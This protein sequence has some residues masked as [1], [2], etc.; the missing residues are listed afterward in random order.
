MSSKSCFNRI[1]RRSRNMRLNSSLQTWLLQLGLAGCRWLFS[2]YSYPRR[3]CH[4]RLPGNDC[5]FSLQTP[6]SL[7][8]P[9]LAVCLCGSDKL[10]TSH[11][12][13]VSLSLVFFFIF[14]QNKP[15]LNYRFLDSSSSSSSLYT[16]VFS[17]RREQVHQF[18]TATRFRPI[19]IAELVIFFMFGKKGKEKWTFIVIHHERCLPCFADD[20]LPSRRGK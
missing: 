18:N 3:V 8:L 4:S 16:T 6:I 2:L 1:I 15:F 5:K 17:S 11:F 10:T 9:S 7:S 20:L 12:H 13:F 19:R 14:W